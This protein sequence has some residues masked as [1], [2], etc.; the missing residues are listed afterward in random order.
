MNGHR[1]GMLSEDRLTFIAAFVDGSVKMGKI[2]F[3]VGNFLRRFV[4]SLLHYGIGI[5]RLS[6]PP[7]GHLHRSALLSKDGGHG[8]VLGRYSCYMTMFGVWVSRKNRIFFVKT[9]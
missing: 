4:L 7:E 1:V 6:V 2:C 3:D 5:C 8:V 9:Q